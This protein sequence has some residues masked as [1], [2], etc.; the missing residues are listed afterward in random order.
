M[1]PIGIEPG[2]PEHKHRKRCRGH[3]QDEAMHAGAQVVGMSFR[4]ADDQVRG[5]GQEPRGGKATDDG[6]RPD[7][8][9]PMQLG[10]YCKLAV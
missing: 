10:P 5:L 7:R 9:K 8:V 4:N 2:A 6:A 1:V 3:R